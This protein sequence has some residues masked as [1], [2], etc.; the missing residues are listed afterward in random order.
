V[1]THVG[2]ALAGQPVTFL[3]QSWKFPGTAAQ[4]PVV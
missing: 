2:I 1:V 3:Q 4:P